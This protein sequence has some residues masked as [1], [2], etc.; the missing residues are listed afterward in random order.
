MK[1]LAIIS[2]AFGTLAACALLLVHSHEEVPSRGLDEAGDRDVVVASRSTESLAPVQESSRRVAVDPMPTATASA[3]TILVR[4]VDTNNTACVGVRAELRKTHLSDEAHWTGCSDA[5]GCIEIPGDRVDSKTN[6]RLTLSQSLAAEALWGELIAS[7]TS[8]E[9]VLRLPCAEQVEVRVLGLPPGKEATLWCGEAQAPRYE[10]K[11]FG[12]LRLDPIDALVNTKG[13]RATLLMH[14]CVD[15]SLR[16]T[17][18]KGRVEPGEFSSPIARAAIFTYRPNPVRPRLGVRFVSA[19]GER[20]KTKALI[21]VRTASNTRSYRV[22]NGV[23]PIAEGPV[24]STSRVTTEGMEVVAIDEDGEMWRSKMR[25]TKPVLGGRLLQL[26]RGK[27][28]RLRRVDPPDWP[29]AQVYL[30]RSDGSIANVE[31]AEDSMDL[32]RF[33]LRTGSKILI[34]GEFGAADRVWFLSA[35]GHAAHVQGSRLVESELVEAVTIKDQ[36]RIPQASA[37][38]VEFAVQLPGQSVDLWITLDRMPARF[39]ITKTPA[40]GMRGRIRLR[41]KEQSPIS[42]RTW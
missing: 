38:A 22:E 41:A 35:D 40:R 31:S 8:K 42:L 27:G 26:E 34:G 30:V 9:L 33:W 5:S 28:V 1:R 16:A 19:G 36:S 13:G 37:I 39:P 11:R 3:S 14:S 23:L 7:T 15:L 12:V 24:L 6:V 29:I 32:K 20:C 18:S 25:G 4:L 17:V 10:S 2:L 21:V